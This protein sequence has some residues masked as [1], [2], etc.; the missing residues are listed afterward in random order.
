VTEPPPEFDEELVLA[1]VAVLFILGLRIGLVTSFHKLS[2]SP[3]LDVVVVCLLS[4]FE[5]AESK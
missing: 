1:I 3:E 4:I 5:L 2:L